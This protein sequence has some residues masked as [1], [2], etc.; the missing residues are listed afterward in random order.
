MNRKSKGTIILSSLAAMGIA[1]SLIAGATYA[2]FTSESKTNIAVTSGTVDVKATL[3]NY[4]T[5]SGTDLTGDV[6][7][8]EAKIVQTE[9]NGTFNN[10]GKASIDGNTLK[11]ENLMPGDR[12]SLEINVTNESTVKAKY[13]T[14][15]KTANN[16]GLFAGLVVKIDNKEFSGF[17]SVSSVESIEPKKGNKTVSVIVDFPSDRGDEY[18]GKK[19]DISFAVEAYQDNAHVDVAAADELRI[20]T[21]D[22]FLTFSKLTNQTDGWFNTPLNGYNTV[23]LM[24]DMDLTGVDWT[25][26]RLGGKKNDIARNIVF[27]GRGKTISNLNLNTEN[28]AVGLFSYVY[29]SQVNNVK[30]TKAYVAGTHWV[31]GIAGHSLVS[32]YNGC[33][34][35]DSTIIN[36]V[37]DNDNGDKTGAIA[38]YMGDGGNVIDDCHVDNVTVQGY[39]DLGGLV[40]HMGAAS[41]KVNKCSVDN[42]TIINDRTFDPEGYGEEESKYNVGH[43]IGRNPGGVVPTE[44][45]ESG[46]VVQIYRGE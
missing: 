1:G 37:K 39:R 30:L 28:E 38:G 45:T 26:I 29:V 3:G 8:D 6:E 40:G 17:T 33:E 5:Y 32:K 27:D 34:V 14:I 23:T 41:D 16:T 44:T 10:G 21:I 12:V 25:P 22:D 24:D 11:L 18:E 4:V 46:V 20:Y 31:A 43:I 7:T 2:L 36:K 42:V 15:V 13:R 9:N 35:T 19:C